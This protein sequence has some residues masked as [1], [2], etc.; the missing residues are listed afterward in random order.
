MLSHFPLLQYSYILIA[1][2]LC[3]FSLLQTQ[4]FLV[5]YSVSVIP[6]CYN[7]CAAQPFY[8]MI[9]RGAREALIHFVE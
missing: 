6:C 8:K 4:L 2:M 7:T 3:H 1:T 9:E 5:Y